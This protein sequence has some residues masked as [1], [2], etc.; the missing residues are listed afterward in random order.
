MA[1]VWFPQSERF[2]M[3]EMITSGNM[4]AATFSAIV[5]AALCLSP[6]GW[7]SAYYVYGI[8][9]SVWLLAWMILAADTP[10]LSKVI[11]ETEKEYLKINVQ[12][13]PKPAPSIPW[14]K[15][16]TS[17]P[18]VACISCQVAFAYSGTIIQGFFPTFLRDELLVPLSL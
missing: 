13:K 2:V 9:A 10:K 17:R 18:L 1:A 6:L 15:V 4:F 3:M 7:P 16:L 8:I 12:P 11:S 5:T 14:R